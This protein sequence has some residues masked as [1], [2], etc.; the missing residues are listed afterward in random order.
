MFG[1][2]VISVL[3]RESLVER[4]F[5]VYTI[6]CLNMLFI[7]MIANLICLCSGSTHV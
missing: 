4:S 2:E 7:K 5:T 6:K 3:Q 1:K